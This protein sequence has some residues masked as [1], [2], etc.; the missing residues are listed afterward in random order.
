MSHFLVIHRNGCWSEDVGRSKKDILKHYRSSQIIKI[1][2]L[3]E[4]TK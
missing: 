3:Y 2:F 1:Y 4:E